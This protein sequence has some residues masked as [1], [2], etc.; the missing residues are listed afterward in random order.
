[1]ESLIQVIGIPW[2]CHVFVWSVKVVNVC[3]KAANLTVFI[4]P[5]DILYNW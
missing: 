3:I 2:Y 4:K 1:L 5:V